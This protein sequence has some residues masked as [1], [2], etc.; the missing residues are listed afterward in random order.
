MVNNRWQD[1]AKMKDSEMVQK[2][3]NLLHTI[4]GAVEKLEL[5]KVILSQKQKDMK[6]SKDIKNG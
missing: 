1:N 2:W 4:E 5:Q 6:N 3:T